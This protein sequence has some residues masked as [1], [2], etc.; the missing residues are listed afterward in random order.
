MRVSGWRLTALALA[1]ALTSRI[2]PAAERPPELRGADRLTAIYDEILAARFDRART[3]LA[4]A[5]PP[6]P[7][8]ACRAL[9]ATAIWWQIVLDPDS[10]ALDAELERTA[11]SAVADATA[12]TLREPQRAEA[13]FYLAGA[14]APLTEW[15]ILRGQR[16]AAARDGNRIRSALERALALDP[17]LVDAK[18]G[19]GLYH[20]YADVAPAAAKVLR[21]LLLLP[22]G[23]RALGLREMLEARDRGVLLRGEAD[24]QLH[25][26]YLWYEHQP[27]RALELL[28]GLDARFPSNPVFL[29]RTAEVLDEYIHDHPGSAETWQ[30]LLDRARAGRM[31]ATGLADTRARL[32]L[33]VELEAMQE[34]DRALDH[35]QTVMRARPPAPFGATARAHVLMGEAY[36]RLGQREAA[37]AAY[38]RALDEDP[39]GEVPGLRTRAQ[40]GL[41]RRSDQT[42]ARAYRLSL[43]GWRALERGDAA[44]A[45]SSLAQATALTPD[46]P[47]M[48]YR[49]SRALAATGDR[50]GA[51]RWL[52]RVVQ[53]QAAVPAFA[54]SAACV[55]LA[56]L[57]EQTRLPIASTRMERNDAGA[58]KGRGEERRVRS[59][60][61]S[62]YE[63]GLSIVGGDRRAQERARTAIARL[64]SERNF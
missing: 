24:F 48:A 13:F 35:L 26:L 4:S 58:D 20:Y 38:Q 16:L 57:I 32:G 25:R 10:R 59:E 14:Y 52:E 49:Y 19:L 7:P 44:G 11:T 47:V 8:E 29:Q 56:A 9:G 39:N 17:S 33:A 51:R 60:A 41:R 34:T 31:A 36:D 12:W 54:L 30:Q 40:A 21:W 64:R 1:T 61:L 45:V 15:R 23:D 3:V 5:C 46:D 2:I 43:D 42:P 53:A 37:V 50:T 63:R 62:L 28:A 55:D 27:Q 18:F 22:G 6:A